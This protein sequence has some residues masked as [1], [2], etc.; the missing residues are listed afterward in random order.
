VIRRGRALVEPDPSVVVGDGPQGLNRDRE[1]HDRLAEA[2]EPG[3]AVGQ[4][5]QQER[6]RV[7]ELTRAV[8]VTGEPT[9]CATR[10]HGV[11]RGRG[12]EAPRDPSLAVAEGER[13]AHQ[14]DQ[15]HR[16]EE[17]EALAGRGEQAGGARPERLGHAEGR[18]VDGESGG[19][20]RGAEQEQPGNAAGP[21]R[22]E[23]SAARGPGSPPTPGSRGRERRP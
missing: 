14:R 20:R 8:G 21:A 18:S 3:Q 16:R 5:E 19:H 11:S 6:H 13:G 12:D 23:R 17:E 1:H 10:E 22:R 2:P 15:D 9:R 7:G 4:E